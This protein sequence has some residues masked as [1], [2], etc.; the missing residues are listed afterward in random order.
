MKRPQ[1]QFPGKAATL[2][3][4]A[5][6]LEP[7]RGYDPPTKPSPASSNRA[8]TTLHIAPTWGCFPMKKNHKANST[9]PK[10]PGFRLWLCQQQCQ[11]R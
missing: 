10:I 7:Q 3:R 1:E 2:G 9:V 5:E 8:L 4:G 11:H 6:K